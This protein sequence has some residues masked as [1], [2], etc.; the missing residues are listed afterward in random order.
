MT[1]PPEPLDRHPGAEQSK[2]VYSP[3]GDSACRFAW[4]LRA[5]LLLVG[6]VAV[7]PIGPV[8]AQDAT[9]SSAPAATGADAELTA[10]VDIGGRVLFLTCQGEGA[11][12][13]I[14]D[15]WTVGLQ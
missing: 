2:R 15:H 11:P 3:W 10:T 14:I 12:T 4:Q 5:L 8:G 9:P 6:A 7:L 1:F 13:V